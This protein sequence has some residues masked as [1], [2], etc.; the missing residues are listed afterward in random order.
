MRLDELPEY[1]TPPVRVRARVR[2]PVTGNKFYMQ[3]TFYVDNR[4][5]LKRLVIKWL[6][7]NQF[8]PDDILS[9]R[10]YL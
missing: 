6:A 8:R 4:E 7:E 9:V 5:M 1:F 2:N 10:V 3:K